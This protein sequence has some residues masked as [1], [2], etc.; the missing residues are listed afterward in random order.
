VR[1]GALSTLALLFVLV[2]GLFLAVRAWNRL[3][4]ETQHELVGAE[5]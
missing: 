3:V 5:P 1:R 4:Q 2:L